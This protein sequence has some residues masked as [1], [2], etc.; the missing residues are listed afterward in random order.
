[1]SFVPILFWTWIRKG[2]PLACRFDSAPLSLLTE[3]RQPTQTHRKKHERI[4]DPLTYLNPSITLI[5]LLAKSSVPTCITNAPVFLHLTCDSPIC[6]FRG[7]PP[8]FFSYWIIL[9]SHHHNGDLSPHLLEERQAKPMTI[10]SMDQNPPTEI[11]IGWWR[12]N[13]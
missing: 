1:M 11:S 4:P 2:E 12:S 10:I 5:E 3:L 6:T 9:P 8:G 7:L 13:V